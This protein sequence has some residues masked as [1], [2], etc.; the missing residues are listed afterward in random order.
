MGRKERGW[1]RREERRRSKEK[2]RK[3]REEREGGGEGRRRRGNRAHIKVS[4][5]CHIRTNGKVTLYHI[6]D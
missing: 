1:R 5:A 6:N 3:R 2:G 4:V